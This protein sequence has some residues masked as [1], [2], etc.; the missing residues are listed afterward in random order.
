MRGHRE[1]CW[2]LFQPNIVVFG[3]LVFQLFLG[4]RLKRL[5]FKGTALPYCFSIDE[6]AT[7]LHLFFPSASHFRM[8]CSMAICRFPFLNPR[9][10]ATSSLN[11][12]SSSSSNVMFILPTLSQIT[13][14]TYRFISFS[15]FNLK[16]NV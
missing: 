1:N 3:L 11:C 6:L 13:L 15:T 9:R 10:L 12:F 7:V 16:R 2:F 14:C 8:A 5:D 4:F